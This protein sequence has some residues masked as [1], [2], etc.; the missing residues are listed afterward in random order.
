[1]EKYNNVNVAKFINYIMQRGKKSVAQNIVYGSFDLVKEKT[2]KEPVEVF[3]QAL[4]NVAPLLEVRS[5]RVGGSNYQVPIPVKGDRK[6]MLS[7]RWIIEAAA[8]KKGAAMHKKL[9]EELVA[10][11]NREGAAVKKRETIHKMAESNRAFA[12]FRR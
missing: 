10:A 5:K 6:L 3:T 1:D 9:A 8:A 11:Y 4:K 7:Y 2:K 12:H